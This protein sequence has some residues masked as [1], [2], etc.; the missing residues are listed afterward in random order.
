MKQILTSKCGTRKAEI[1]KIGTKYNL[2]RFV[3]LPIIKEWGL[4]GGQ[5]EPIFLEFTSKKEA[6][7]KANDYINPKK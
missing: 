1:T 7:K 3:L 5:E 4:F 6:I 2:L